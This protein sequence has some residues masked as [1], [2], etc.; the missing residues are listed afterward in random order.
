MLSAVLGSLLAVTSAAVS[1][2]PEGGTIAARLNLLPEEADSTSVVGGEL[3]P[4]AGTPDPVATDA[5]PAD[6]SAP[7]E[8]AGVAE[9]AAGATAD[10]TASVA[11]PKADSSAAASPSTPGATEQPAAE[12]QQ[13]EAT[14][15]EK[16]EKKE[17]PKSVAGPRRR[18]DGFGAPAA[19][20]APDFKAYVPTRIRYVWPF[21]KEHE[22]LPGDV[23]IPLPIWLMAVGGGA[24]IATGVPFYTLARNAESR[25][26]NGDT[27]LR[28]DADRAALLDHGRTME[29]IG[30]GLWVAGG[31]LI[32]TSWTLFYVVGTQEKPKGL[33]YSLSVGP[34]GGSVSLT[35]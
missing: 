14:P 24:S 19:A 33:N 5:A 3:A 29:A 21:A 26:V 7:A 25:L 10:P 35:F 8:G 32:A 16:E 20:S 18:M 2:S 30:V 23:R 34:G 17:E 15:E 22:L 28:T 11:P 31:A 4:D 12:A 27:S 1:D 9:G 13:A 6:A